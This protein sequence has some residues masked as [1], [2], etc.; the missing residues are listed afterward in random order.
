M[1][2]AFRVKRSVWLERELDSGFAT[3]MNH[4]VEG[5]WADLPGVGGVPMAPQELGSAAGILPARGAQ[6]S[7]NFIRGWV[8]S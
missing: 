4:H 7:A 8:G 2:P 1:H 5:G 3:L 6:G